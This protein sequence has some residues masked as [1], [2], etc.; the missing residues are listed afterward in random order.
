MNF[1]FC[2]RQLWGAKWACVCVYVRVELSIAVTRMLVRVRTYKAVRNGRDFS[3]SNILQLKDDWYAIFAEKILIALVHA[4]ENE[5]TLLLFSTF[6]NGTL[7]AEREDVSYRFVTEPRSPLT[8][9]IF[10]NSLSR[11]CYPLFRMHS[12]SPWRCSPAKIYTIFIRYHWFVSSN[13]LYPFHRALYLSTCLYIRSYTYI[14]VVLPICD[15][16]TYD[17]TKKKRSE[18]DLENIE[19]PTNAKN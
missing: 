16:K 8:A 2:E 6:V 1:R 12:W 9:S 3:I 7:R 11:D 18:D 5:I 19:I 17:P 14:F 13:P 10:E 15:E 4:R